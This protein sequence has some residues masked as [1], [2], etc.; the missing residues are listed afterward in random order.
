LSFLAI[1]ICVVLCQASIFLKCL[2]TSFSTSFTCF[3][4][5]FDPPALPAG[6]P[7]SCRLSISSIYLFSISIVLVYHVLLGKSLTNRSPHRRAS[8]FVMRF[9]GP[10]HKIPSG[11]ILIHDKKHLFEFCFELFER[12][13]ATRI[14]MPITESRDERLFQRPCKMAPEVIPVSRRHLAV[15]SISKWATSLDQVFVWGTAGRF[16]GRIKIRVRMKTTHEDM[17]YNHGCSKLHLMNVP[18]VF[19]KFRFLQKLG[20]RIGREISSGDVLI[21]RGCLHLK[22]VTVDKRNMTGIID[23]KISRIEVIDQDTVI[24]ERLNF[25]LMC[26]ILCFLK[27]V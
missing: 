4:C 25:L 24:R 26:F 19:Q 27:F 14:C 13:P 11:G 2:E 10:R 20:C 8:F 17:K 18:W 12:C 9:C 21:A 7:I 3:F 1:A 16:V 15:R 5:F 6:V 23:K 22:T